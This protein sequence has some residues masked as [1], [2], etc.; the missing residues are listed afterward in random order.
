MTWTSRFMATLAAL[1]AD[2]C[3]LMLVLFDSCDL[4]SWLSDGCLSDRGVY[5]LRLPNE[6]P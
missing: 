3:C 6:T 5:W 4:P 1:A 2:I